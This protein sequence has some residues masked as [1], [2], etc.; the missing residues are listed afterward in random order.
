MALFKELGVGS[1]E[2]GDGRW[3]LGDGRSFVA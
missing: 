3:E 1:G 2:L